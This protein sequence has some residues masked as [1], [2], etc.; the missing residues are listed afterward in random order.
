MSECNVK[1]GMCY[2]A[3]QG[4]DLQLLQFTSDTEMIA[5]VSQKMNE[6]I[7]LMNSICADLSSLDA[8]VK[9]LE[10]KNE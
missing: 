8:R 7:C 3:L 2:P 10:E 9:A 1:F 6:V 4:F 5:Y